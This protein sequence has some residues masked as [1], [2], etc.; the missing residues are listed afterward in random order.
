MCQFI[1]LLVGTE[2]TRNVPANVSSYTIDGLQP[3][4]AYTIQV[5]ALVGSREGGP[6]ILN[7]RT[8]ILL[9]IF[10]TTVVA[11]KNA[12]ATTGKNYMKK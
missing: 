12:N 6:A 10:S 11:F 4:S 1:Y 8:G 7:V 9:N 5:A 3:N 2:T